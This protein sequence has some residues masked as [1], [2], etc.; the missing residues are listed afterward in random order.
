MG[1]TKVRAQEEKEEKPKEKKV[2]RPTKILKPEEKELRAIV[3]VAGSD[4]DGEMPLRNALMGIK[5]IGYVMSKAICEVGNFD[6]NVKLGSLTAEEMIRLEAVI[7][8]PM[9][10][11]VPSWALN[12]RREPETGMDMHLTGADLEVAKKF[13]VQKMINLKTYRGMRHMLGQPVR[14]QRTRSSFRGGRVVGV[15]KKT[16]K[17]AMEKKEEEEK[18]KK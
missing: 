7:K 6:P 2:A 3:R 8:E 15:V 9:K 18:K 13:D 17:F 14:G 5:G 16:I 1:V 10:F 11:G 4:L 12:R